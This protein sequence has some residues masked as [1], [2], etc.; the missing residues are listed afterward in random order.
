[1]ADQKVCSKEE[2]LDERRGQQTGHLMAM[3][4]A[5]TSAPPL[6]GKRAATMV[7]WW[8]EMTAA[9]RAARMVF[10]TGGSWGVHLALQLAEHWES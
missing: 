9:M 8:A 6:V 2:C 1:M 5:A 3:N 7:R 10:P 4:S